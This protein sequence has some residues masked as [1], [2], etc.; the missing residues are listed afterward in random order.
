MSRALGGDLF[1]LLLLR[2][3]MS[4]ITFC[5][6]GALVG[7]PL[8]AQAP[9]VK[10]TLLIR[11][12]D[13]SQPAKCRNIRALRASHGAFRQEHSAEHTQG[14][15]PPACLA[16]ALDPRR[17]TPRV[18]RPQ[19]RMPPHRVGRPADAPSSCAPNAQLCGV[20]R[21]ALVAGAKREHL[22]GSLS[23]A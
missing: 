8:C 18:Q 20:L 6:T 12:T 14:C 9:F 11:L 19:R 10:P 5:L 15:R 3:R 2:Q 1:R 17:A 4:A 13:Q 23:P 16:L 22:C 7:L 21:R